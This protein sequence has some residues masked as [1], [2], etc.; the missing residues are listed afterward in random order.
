M[1]QWLG[2]MVVPGTVLVKVQIAGGQLTTLC[3]ILFFVYVVEQSRQ[4]VLFN[5]FH[6]RMRRSGKN[7]VQ[8]LVI[9]EISFARLGCRGIECLHK[10]LNR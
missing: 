10:V 8:E 4:I 6:N 9:N 1:G 2:S 3:L 5:L 7:I